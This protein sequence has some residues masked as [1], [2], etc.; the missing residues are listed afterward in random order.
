MCGAMRAIFPNSGERTKS[1]RISSASP[2]KN[3]SIPM[4]GT[5]FAV[6]VT[7][8]NW[9]I[10]LSCCSRLCGR[11]GEGADGHGL[12][13]ALHVARHD[14]AAEQGRDERHGEPRGLPA[15]VEIGVHFH[16]IERAHEPAVMQHLH[17]QM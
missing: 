3:V 15:A 11:T 17:D 13:L 8:M 16:D 2:L 5:S 12:E 4:L 9:V 10:A 1:A 7:P 6:S 14:L